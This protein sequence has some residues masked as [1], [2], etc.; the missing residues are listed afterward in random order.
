MFGK[1]DNWR[2]VRPQTSYNRL[3][4][5]WLAFPANLRGI[6]WLSAGTLVLALTDSV[7]KILGQTLHPVELSFFR[8]SVGFLMLAPVFW[9]MGVRGPGLLRTQRP[10]LHALRL[11]LA[12][13][14]QTG[15]FI[16]L[17]NMKLADATALWFSKPLFTTVVAIFILSELVPPRRWVAMIIG[18]VGVI[19]MLRPGAGVVDPYALIAVGA[20]LAMA[21]ANILIRVMAPT[22]PPNRILFYYHVGGVVLL[23]CPALWFWQTPSGWEWG[24]IVL[25]G[26][27]QTF[28]MICFVR[29]FSIGEA[30]AIAPSEYLRLIYAGLIGYFM[31]GESVDS[32]TIAGAAIIVGSTLYIAQDEARRPVKNEPEKPPVPRRGP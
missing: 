28:G 6:I 27:G 5:K 25:L 23:A 17:V 31:F 4:G 1:G 29:G 15:I 11:L 2:P 12:T 9:R 22:E 20:A 13:L 26:A 14:G 10:G 21:M 16:A 3:T 8:Y 18:F 19:I 7:L 30:N 32:W 24:L